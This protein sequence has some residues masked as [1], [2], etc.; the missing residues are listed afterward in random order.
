MNIKE[1][2]ASLD[3]DAVKEL[4]K[5][6]DSKDDSKLQNYVGKLFDKF[7]PKEKVESSVAE[8]TSSL[9]IMDEKGKVLSYLN[10]DNYEWLRFKG[11]R[12]KSIPYAGMIV[13]LAPEDIIGVAKIVDPYGKYKVIIPSY[14]KNYISLPKNIVDL[15]KARCRPFGGNLDLIFKSAAQRELEKVLSKFDA[16]VIDEFKKDFNGKVKDMNCI[17]KAMEELSSMKSFG[18][19]KNDMKAALNDKFEEIKKQIVSWVDTLVNS[20]EEF[21]KDNT[22]EDS[23]KKAIKDYMDSIKK[24]LGILAKAKSFKETSLL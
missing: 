16:N 17:F 5:I 21:L 19:L 8:N 7:Q 3:K 15:I 6:I 12:N 13:K 23:D 22:L 9:K 10:T 20:T 11:A 24:A 1:I 4:T 14:K 18:D 2:L